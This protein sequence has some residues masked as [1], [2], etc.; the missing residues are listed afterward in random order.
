MSTMKQIENILIEI[1]RKVTTLRSECE[2]NRYLNN[3]KESSELCELNG[4]FSSIKYT[5]ISN[6]INRSYI[7]E[8]EMGYQ[9]LLEDTPL[10]S[11]GLFIPE[12]EL[13]TLARSFEYAF[14]LKGAS[15]KITY[16]FV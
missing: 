3:T 6:L 14:I 16:H 12:K 13:Y 7:T 9:N 10:F 5:D 4:L 8:N 15:R 11:V 2:L 1:K